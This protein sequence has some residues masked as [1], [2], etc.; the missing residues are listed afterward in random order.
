MELDNIDDEIFEYIR[1]KL[2]IK[3]SDASISSQAGG[4]MPGDL[5]VRVALELYDS[6]YK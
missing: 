4:E 5:K 6:I 1:T 3:V 2:R